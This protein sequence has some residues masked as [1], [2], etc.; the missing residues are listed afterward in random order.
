MKISLQIGRFDWPGNPENTGETLAEIAKTTDRNGFSSLFVMDHFYQLE[1]MV[2][3]ADDPMLEA[4]NTLGFL[5]GKTKNVKLGTLVTGNLYRNPGLL[6]K[7]VSTL[8]VLSKGRS[9]LGIGTGW[10]EREAEGLGF[11][12]P[13]WNELFERLEETLKIAKQMFSGDRSPFNGKY[14]KLS[15]PINSPQ[16]ISK[17]HPP[18]LIGGEG[19]RKT[20][21]LVSK[22]GDACNFFA[23][24]DNEK[25]KHKLKVLKKHCDKLGRPFNE[26]EKTA[27]T[28]A[29]FGPGSINPDM[30]IN[31]CKGLSA[32]GIEHLIFVLPKVHEITPIEIFGEEIIPAVSEI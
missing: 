6:I 31:S 18:I 5:A 7:A 16:T 23:F 4:Y 27:F 15:E 11:T 3:K 1:P 19:E 24:G 13:D 29:F 12:F 28:M 25:I 9:Y 14:Y 22:Y 21:Y 2:G 30:V 10:Y 20:L 32:A 8:D 17:P 26:I